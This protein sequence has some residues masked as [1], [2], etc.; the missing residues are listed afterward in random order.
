M[1][2][3]IVSPLTT[4]S[5]M[6]VLLIYIV[7]FESFNLSAIK[8]IV[9]NKNIIIDKI[10]L[11]DNMHIEFNFLNNNKCC[12]QNKMFGSEEWKDTLKN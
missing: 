9:D 5:F 8:K 3:Y 4:Q 7:S 6:L 10:F 1:P 12:I 2:I 11:N